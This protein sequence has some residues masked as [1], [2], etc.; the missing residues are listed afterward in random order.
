MRLFLIVL[1][2]ALCV[3]PTVP[4]FE[5]EAQRGDLDLNGKLDRDDL[6]ILV[7]VLHAAKPAPEYFDQLGDFNGDGVTN[8]ADIDAFAR[9]LFD[10]C[11]ACMGCPPC[12]VLEPDPADIL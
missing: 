12:V 1:I 5:T 11:E 7:N 6:L 3:A 2:F 8:A 4:A 10:G 9:Y